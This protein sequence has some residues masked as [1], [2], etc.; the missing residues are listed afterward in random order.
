M[1]PVALIRSTQG[2]SGKQLPKSEV[3]AWVSSIETAAS[4]ATLPKVLEGDPI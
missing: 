2:V 4:G 1:A 3:I